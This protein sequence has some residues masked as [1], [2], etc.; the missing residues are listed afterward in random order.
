MRA[1]ELEVKKLRASM[2]LT[3][4]MMTLLRATMPIPLASLKICSTCQRMHALIPASR[5]T[6]TN[7][8]SIPGH[9]WECSCGSTLFQPTCRPQDRKVA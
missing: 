9:Y 1:F 3:D 6:E 8:D 5:R 7:N 2:A 4:T